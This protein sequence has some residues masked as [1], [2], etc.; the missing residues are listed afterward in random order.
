MLST[1]GTESGVCVC[2]H[3]R[4]CMHVRACMC[5]CV[6]ARAYV[7]MHVCLCVRMPVRVCVLEPQVIVNLYSPPQN[8]TH[9]VLLILKRQLDVWKKCHCRLSVGLA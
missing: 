7:C 5:V 2:V 8:S 6:C 4:M 9:K 1:A 3:V